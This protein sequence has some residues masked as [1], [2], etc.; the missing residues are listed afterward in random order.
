M[1]FHPIETLT[2]YLALIVDVK[3]GTADTARERECLKGTSAVPEAI[4]GLVIIAYPVAAY[5]LS[6]IVEAKPVEV[7]DP[8]PLHVLAQDFEPV[9]VER[10]LTAKTLTNPSPGVYVYD[11][12]QNLAGIER[13]HL[14]GR[15]GQQLKLRF[16]EVLN[17]DGTLYTANLRT[18]KATDFDTMS[19]KGTETFQPQFTFHGFR[20]AELVF[21]GDR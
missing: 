12:G 7:V 19:G 8:S 20:Y 10:V 2:D 11:F 13:V 16:A 5:Q 9:R 1:A 17:S 3:S 21:A 4:G 6:V 14:A 18:A 15:A